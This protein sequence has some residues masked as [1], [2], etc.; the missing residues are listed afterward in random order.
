[1]GVVQRLERYLSRCCPDQ[2]KRPCVRLRPCVTRRVVEQPPAGLPCG[3]SQPQHTRR[4]QPQRRVPPCQDK[5]TLWF[6]YPFTLCKR[7]KQARQGL[8]FLY[9]RRVNVLHSA[10]PYIYTPIY[11]V[12]IHAKRLCVATE[13]IYGEIT[14]AYIYEWAQK[15]RRGL[16]PMKGYQ[17]RRCGGYS[18]RKLFGSRTADWTEI[19]HARRVR[20]GGGSGLISLYW[21]GGTRRCCCDC[22]VCC[23]CDSPHGSS[24]GCC[25]TTRRVT[26]GWSLWP[27]ALCF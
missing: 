19:C 25:S 22:R 21:Q 8:L 5:V 3:V 17:T 26:H 9:H 27:S 15:N 24:A 18:S 7:E 10:E 23:C 2:S 11:G 4:S 14:G 16:R 13:C 20:K 6:F 12:Y 1:M